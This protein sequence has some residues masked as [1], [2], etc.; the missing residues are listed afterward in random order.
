MLRR[1]GNSYQRA[2]QSCQ[3]PPSAL[4][5]L[6]N[7]SIRLR[8]RA[9]SRARQRGLTTVEYVVVL[10][11][12]AIVSVAAWRVFGG[13]VRRA[14][15]LTGQDLDT[16]TLAGNDP[17]AVRAAPGSSAPSPIG[18]VIV[19]RPEPASPPA[20]DKSAKS[21]EGGGGSPPRATT[22]LGS[23]VDNVINRS[24]TLARDVA[25]LR[26]QRWTYSYARSG[27]GTFTD[28]NARRIYLDGDERGSP[29]DAAN[30]VA[31]ES[32]HALNPPAT[33]Q[34]SGL[35]RA[36]FIKKN[37]DA[38]LAGE[39]AATLYNAQVREEILANGGPD[40]G[41]PGKQ[42]KTYTAIYEDY[43]AGKLT[44]SEAEA[45]IAEVYGARENTAYANQNYRQYYAEVYGRRWDRMYPDKP[46]DFRAP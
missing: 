39:G 38:E 14:V 25:A 46:K 8:R 26:A 4:P 19:R 1:I 40:I 33:V 17:D 16:L 15:D 18:E 37:V 27:A 41:I 45:R 23:D 11:L 32:G 29:R 35:T 6:S 44:K 30:S 9:V 5:I 24:P 31:H 20:G 21:S 3:K 22:S 13:T 36:E 43:K 34:P 12:V 2:L 28:A 7:H 42:S 10:I